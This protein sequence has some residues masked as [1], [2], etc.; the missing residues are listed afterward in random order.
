MKVSLED[1]ESSRNY[2]QKKFLRKKK[3]SQ[4]ELKKRKRKEKKMNIR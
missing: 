4:N 3:T 1:Q 2:L